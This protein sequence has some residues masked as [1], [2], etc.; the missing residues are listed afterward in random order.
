M[1]VGIA[2]LGCAVLAGL[3]LQAS[4]EDHLWEDTRHG[5]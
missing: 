4:R 2:S 1:N 3:R 5:N